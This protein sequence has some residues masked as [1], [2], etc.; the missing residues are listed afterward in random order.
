[1]SLK[2]SKTRI[3]QNR[4]QH[5]GDSGQQQ[6]LSQQL[7]NNANTMRTQRHPQSNLATTSDCTRQQKTGDIGTRDEQY[8]SDCNQ[9]HRQRATRVA[10]QLIA[11]RHHDCP[12]FAVKSLSRMIGSNSSH[13]GVHV[14]LCLRKTPP[15]LQARD[16]LQIVSA[17]IRELFLVQRE[18]H[19]QTHIVLEKLKASRHHTNDRVLLAIKK[20]LAI[21]DAPVATVATLPKA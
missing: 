1:K 4:S 6:T 18:R 3:R 21:D 11:Q 10:N 7:S 9:Q 2:K 13:H 12:E 17:T 19:P 20:N 8:K 15:R 16:D 14:C 5:T